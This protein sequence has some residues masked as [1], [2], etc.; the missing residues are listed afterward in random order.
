[1]QS[2]IDAIK[3]IG[4]YVEGNQPNTFEVRNRYVAHDNDC[5]DDERDDEF[6]ERYSEKFSRWANPIRKQVTELAKTY[7]VKISFETA[8][9]YGILQVVIV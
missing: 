9:E 5:S 6:Y 7:G 4:F 8:S 2:F 1:V 3:R